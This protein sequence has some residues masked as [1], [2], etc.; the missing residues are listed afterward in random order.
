MPSTC[1]VGGCTYTRNKTKNLDISFVLISADSCDF[2]GMGVTNN[3][4]RVL[5]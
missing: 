2:K 4:L 1:V 3:M 5:H